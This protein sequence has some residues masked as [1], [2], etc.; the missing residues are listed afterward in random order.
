MCVCVCVRLCEGVLK[1]SQAQPQFN[2]NVLNYTIRLG[3][4]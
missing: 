1:K 4:V 2:L 3:W